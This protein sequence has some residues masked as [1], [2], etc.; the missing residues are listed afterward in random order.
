MKATKKF[1]VL[2]MKMVINCKK[3]PID[4]ARDGARRGTNRGPG[5]PEL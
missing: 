2:E 5:P 4:D 3:N 1:N